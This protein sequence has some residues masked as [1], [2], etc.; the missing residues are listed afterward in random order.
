[1]STGVDGFEMFCEHFVEVE[2]KQ[3]LLGRSPLKLFEGQKKVAPDLVSGRWLCILKG[4][5][6]GITTLIAAYVLWCVVFRSYCKVCVVFQEKTY[7]EDFVATIRDIW[8]GLP[9]WLRP[10]ITTDNLQRLVFAGV[11]WMGNEYRSEIRALVGSE[12]TGRS[13]TGDIVIIDEASR[14]AGLDKTLQAVLPVIEVAGGQVVLLS[15]SAG[16]Q[17][18]FHGMW[19]D[20]FGEYGENVATHEALELAVVKPIFLHWSGRPGRDQIWYEREKIR[21]TKLGGA[22]AIKQEH[23]NNPQEAWEYA[24]GRVYVK[25]ERDRH[26]G[27]IDIPTTAERYRA[28]DW[29]ESASPFVCLWIAH[30]PGPPGVLISPECP[31]TIREMFAY[32]WDPD[33]PNDPLKQDDHCPDALRYAV[34]T[35]NLRGLIYVYREWYVKDILAKGWNPMTEIAKIHEMSGW[36]INPDVGGFEPGLRGE[37]YYQSV[38]DR[39]EG[40]LIKLFSEHNLDVVS[41]VKPKFRKDRRTDKKEADPPMKEVVQGIHMVGALLDAGYHLETRMK[42]NR[43]LEAARSLAEDEAAHNLLASRGLRQTVIA[44]EAQRILKAR[45]ELIKRGEW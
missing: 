14:V 26:V 10:T 18:V 20:T 32:R 7:A 11:D 27:T 23:P 2:D 25:F 17:G 9:W 37:R 8:T 40:A 5:Q 28:I 12:K 31:N 21:L 35:W 43:T 39:S 38:A 36:E 6:L 33:R 34:V 13:M 1:M 44:H 19:M 16:P 42:V 4:R 3:T 29:G 15:S 30:V 45:E 41:H 22:I 24:A